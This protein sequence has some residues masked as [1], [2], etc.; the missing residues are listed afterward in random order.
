MLEQFERYL[1]EEGK[2]ENTIKS[3]LQSIA[4]FFEMV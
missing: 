2:S 3:Y 1:R 4:G